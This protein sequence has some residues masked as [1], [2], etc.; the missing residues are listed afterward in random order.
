MLDDE[1]APP[2]SRAVWSGEVLLVAAPM[3]REVGIRRYECN[4]GALR[5]TD[6]E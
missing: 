3:E 2:G 5:R 6:H 4:E 1:V